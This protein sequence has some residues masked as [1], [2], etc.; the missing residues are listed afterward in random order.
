MAGR[1]T[2]S[3]QA[4]NKQAMKDIKSALDKLP[5]EFSIRRR[6]TILKKGLESFI[7]T[8]KSK[9]PVDTGQLKEA[10]ST[11]TFRNNKAF[12][13]GGVVTKGS[14]KS[15][16]GEKVKIDGFYAKFLEY[17]FDH[18][19]WPEKGFR[20]DRDPIRENRITKIPAKRHAFLRPAWDETKLKVKTD[21]INLTEKRVKAYE[22]KV[23]KRNTV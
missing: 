16:T 17:G 5:K 7:N 21:T 15:V 19:A 11:K 18:I 20:L 9:A 2:N 13:F 3:I 10:I 4:F 12:V 23:K 1:G 22:R 6:R 8:A 14:T